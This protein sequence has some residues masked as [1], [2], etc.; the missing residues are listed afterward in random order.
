MR[1]VGQSGSA[2]FCRLQHENDLEQTAEAAHDF[3]V[4]TELT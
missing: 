4:S 2:V 3:P 1:A